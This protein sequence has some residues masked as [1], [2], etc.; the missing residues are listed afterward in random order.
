MALSSDLVYFDIDLDF[1]CCRGRPIA[2]AE[3]FAFCEASAAAAAEEF[4][5]AVMISNAS[6][7]SPSLFGMV[8]RNGS[9][10]LPYRGSRDSK[11]GS[12]VSSSTDIFGQFK[13]KFNF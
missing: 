11:S 9:S 10:S 2:D 8:M 7:S 12:A 6:S 4:A 5:P 3:L 1:Y 13:S